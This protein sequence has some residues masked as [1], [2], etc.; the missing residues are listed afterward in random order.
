MLFYNSS[1]YRIPQIHFIKE[2]KVKA[3]FLL[4]SMLEATAAQNNAHD[5]SH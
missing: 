1:S 3:L 5:N 2:K 4:T